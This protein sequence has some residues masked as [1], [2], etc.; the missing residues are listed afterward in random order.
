MPQQNRRL[1]VVVLGSDFKGLGVIRSLGQRG[2]PCVLIDNLPRSAWFSRYVTKRF[3]WDGPL[4][5]DDFLQFLLNIGEEHHFIGWVLFPVQDD[6]VEFVAHHTSQLATS[7]CLVTQNWDVVR[8]AHDKR[9]TYRMAHEVG[10]PYPKTWYPDTEEQLKT[11]VIT[12]PVIIKPAISI[13]LQH[14]LRL[15]ALPVHTMDELL[16]QYHLV[17]DIIHPQEIMIQEI[18]PGDGR[19][20]YAVGTFCKNG[21]VL[22]SITVRRTRQYPIDYGLGS[23]FVEAIEVPAITQLAEKLLRMM[24]LSGMVEVEFKYDARDEQY[25]LLDINPRPW[26]WHTLCIQCGLDLPYIQ[27]CDAL[28]HEIAAP[29][30]PYYGRR[31]IR[32]LTDIPAGLQEI[33][34]GITTPTA[35]VHSLLGKTTFSVFAWHDPL[36]ALGDLGVALSRLAKMLPQKLHAAEKLH[37]TEPSQ[38][39]TGT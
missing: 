16:K 39:S 9:L 7:Y 17:A 1:G 23:S 2:I 37:T 14:A 22:Q 26:G 30:K 12:F 8:W 3:K 4:N 28:G 29:T 32:L 21:Q 10:M 33:R 20:Q 15:K 19:T 31:W 38:C 24:G 34:V 5:T 11:L 27:Y 25:K 36:P 35:Y 6:A 18:I 13:H